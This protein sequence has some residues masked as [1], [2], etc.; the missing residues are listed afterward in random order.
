MSSPSSQTFECRWQPSILLSAL[1]LAILLTAIGLLFALPLASWLR[2]CALSLCLGH[3]AWVL[4]TRILLLSQT[5]WRGLRHQPQ[6]WSLWNPADG[7]QPVQL[8]PDCIAL[9]WVV[10]LRFRRPGQWFVRSLCLVRGALPASQHRRL[11]L[12]LKFSRRRWAAPE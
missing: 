5:S 7:W 9:P 8:R 2:L 12:R 3:A 1:Y 10:V 6:G 11:R 4:P